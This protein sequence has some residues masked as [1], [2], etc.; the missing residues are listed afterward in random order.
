MPGI[1]PSSSG[2]S[3]IPDAIAARRA[4]VAPRAHRQGSTA[5]VPLDQL[6]MQL[7]RKRAHGAVVVTGPPGAGKSTALSHLRAVLSQDLP[8]DVK[9][10]FFDEPQYTH[11]TA[12]ARGILAVVASARPVRALETFELAPWSMDDCLEY[13]A[14][15]HRNI[16][17]SVLRRMHG[18][19][20]LPLLEGSPQLLRIVMDRMAA[21]ASLERVS[22]ALRRHVWDV[23]PPGPARREAASMLYLNVLHD[24]QDPAAVAV[25]ASR[26]A[27]LSDEAN[28]LLRH[29]I[30]R[31]IA[32]AEWVA[33]KLC[34][35]RSQRISIRCCPMTSCAN[36]P[37]P[38]ASVRRRSIGWTGSSRQATA[39]PTRWPPASSCAL[40][41]SG[42][43]PARVACG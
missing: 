29:R 28:R 1:E 40:S 38:C 22:D 19:Q 21:D 4:P 31:I 2:R 35:V 16:C 20:T 26:R 25:H 9:I 23:L 14:A 33:S 10:G 5:C 27:D 24:K 36:S 37:P 12:A 39:A 32:A 13:L 7:V 34:E 43:P 18:D 17:T 3:S 6:I 41:R 30:V 11:W 8:H 42:D 15:T